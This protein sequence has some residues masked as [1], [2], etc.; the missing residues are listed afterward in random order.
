MAWPEAADVDKR[1]ELGVDAQGYPAGPNLAPAQAARP[2]RPVRRRL[3]HELEFLPAA[4]EAVETPPSPMARAVSLLIVL[5]AFIALAW[6]WIGQI[7]ITAVTRGRIIPSDRNKLVQPLEPGI[8][9]SI[10]VAEGQRV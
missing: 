4:L 9:R 2:Q 3:G 7:D 10:H 5:F 6:A 1:E 8:V